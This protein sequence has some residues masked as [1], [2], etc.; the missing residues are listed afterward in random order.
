MAFF[1]GTFFPLDRFPEFL[2]SLIRILP[3]T[4][5]NIVIRKEYLDGDALTSLAVLTIYTVFF[6]L[7]GSQLIRRYSE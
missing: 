4:H 1:S 5:T 6:I 3:L 2:K 7:Y